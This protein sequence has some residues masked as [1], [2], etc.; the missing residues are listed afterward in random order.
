MALV[1]VSLHSNE[2]LTK[3]MPL[4]PA[5][6]NKRQASLV[7]RPNSRTDR[8][9]Q[10]PVPNQPAKTQPGLVVAIYNHT[11]LEVEAGRSEI[12]ACAT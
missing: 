6:W 2:T 11:V 10:T 9:T 3:T 12:Q 8:D 7:Y 5:L 1:L 4:I